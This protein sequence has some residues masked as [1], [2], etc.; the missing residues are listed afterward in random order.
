V[1]WCLLCFVFFGLCKFI[2][3]RYMCK[4]CCHRVKII[5]WLMII[6]IKDNKPQYFTQSRDISIQY[7]D[8]VSLFVSSELGTQI[9]SFSPRNVS[10]WSQIH[11]ITQEQRTL[12]QTL[13]TWQY[14]DQQDGHE[15]WHVWWRGEL[16]T[17]I[18]YGKLHKIVSWKSFT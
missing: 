17:G 5:L 10:L 2:L 16:P 11:D 18:W 8:S 15:M 4:D 13:S 14:Q 12:D 1:Y 6:K 9:T 7:H 3:I